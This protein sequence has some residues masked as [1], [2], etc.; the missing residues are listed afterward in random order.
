MVKVTIFGQQSLEHYIS[1]I[2]FKVQFIQVYGI[3]Q[4]YTQLTIF[5]RHLR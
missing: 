3:I 2:N 1:K 5:G 4:N